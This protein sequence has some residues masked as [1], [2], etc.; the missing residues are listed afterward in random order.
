VVAANR[1]R[2]LL[3]VI[4]T[5]P[6]D[7]AKRRPKLIGQ[8]LPLAKADE[9]FL[10]HD[11]FLDCSEAHDD[12]DKDKIEEILADDTS[13]MLGSLSPKSAEQVLEMIT[14]SP[15]LSLLTSEKLVLRSPPCFNG[16]NYTD[17]ASYTP[18]ESELMF[19]TKL[20]GR[21]PRW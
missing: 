21:P 6:T 5:S 3:F 12:F 8:H 2:P 16:W 13:L 11:S 19:L 15:T 7:F 17:S 14:D 4:N 20:L 1:K 10:D 9:N 18:N